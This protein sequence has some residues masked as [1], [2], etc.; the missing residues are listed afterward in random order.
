MGHYAASDRRRVARQHR[1]G[2]GDLHFATEPEIH[3]DESRTGRH[4]DRATIP[5]LL[6]ARAGLL[7]GCA[8]FTAARAA[9]LLQVLAD[10]T[11]TEMISSKAIYVDDGGRHSNSEQTRRFPDP[12]TRSNRPCILTMLLTTRKRDTART[13]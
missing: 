5:E 4:H 6:G 3:G 13:R 11:S 9:A 8:C 1:H 7:V 2:R 12:L 10:V